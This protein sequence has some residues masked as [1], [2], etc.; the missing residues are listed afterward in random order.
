MK[1]T[2]RIRGTTP[3]IDEAARAMRRSMTE[4]EAALWEELRS[5]RLGGFKFRAQHPVGAFVLDF[6]CPS[7]RLVV[8]VDGGSHRE[9]AERDREWTE[10]LNAHGYRVVRFRNEEVLSDIDAVVAVI[11]EFLAAE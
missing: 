9:R 8:E 11:A 3:E 4:A 2:P 10:I 7:R 5:R 1:T 6:C